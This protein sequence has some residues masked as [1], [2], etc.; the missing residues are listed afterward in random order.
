MRYIRG[1]RVD[2]QGKLWVME[3]DSKPRRVSVWDA[4]TGAFLKEFF[5]PTDYGAL[6]GAIDPL[7]PYTMV[8]H[9]CEWKL[10]PTTGKASCVAVFNQG[11]MGNSRFGLGPNN[12]LY[13][14][15]STWSKVS[16]VSIY[17]RIAP[18]Q[19]K[20]RAQLLPLT[21][22]T[23]K[24]SQLA[25]MIVWSDINGDEQQQPEET[26][27]YPLDLGRWINGWY[28]PM[29]QSMI[30]YGGLYRIA[31][32]GWTACGAPEYDLTQAKRMPAPADV[33]TRGGSNGSEDGR[34]VVYE[35]HYNTANSDFEC[36]DIDKG[37]L[38][39]TYPNNYVGVHGGHKAP[40]PQVGLIRGAYDI[41]GTGKLPDPIGDI[42]VI[43]TD[44]GEWHVLTGEG[45]YLTK[46][47][48][49]DPMKIQ[50]PSPAAPGAVMDAVPP[51]MGAEDFGGSIMVTKDGELYLQAG[52]TATLI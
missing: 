16:P 4:Q 5:G 33:A 25:G 18:G 37:T 29:T 2:A 13:L 40:P 42:F 26:H 30:F 11:A 27:R 23:G 38:K 12:R 45:Y 46:F 19:W 52:K 48:E 28:M 17:E 31:P 3:S 51:G 39:W 21:A 43:G 50:W 47:F 10:D 22:E 15:V 35:G 14:A 41:V 9:G 44:K 20:L 7:D 49:S 24:S 32:T 8:G 36:F 6:G 34:L 1:L